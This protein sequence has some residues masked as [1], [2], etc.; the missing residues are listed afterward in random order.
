[1]KILEF[2]NSSTWTANHN[3]FQ[4][5]A[6]PF[7]LHNLTSSSAVGYKRR[8]I[9]KLNAYQIPAAPRYANW[10]WRVTS[11]VAGVAFNEE[12]ERK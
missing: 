4:S 1:L 9:M 3:L 11:R 6:L 2:Y 8:T 10:Y 12:R 7:L 5:D